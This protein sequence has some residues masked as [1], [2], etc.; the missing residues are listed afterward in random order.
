LPGVSEDII[1]FIS[2]LLN[3][4]LRPDEYIFPHGLSGSQHPLI[5]TS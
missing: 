5:L 1:S 3:D 2:N 4:K